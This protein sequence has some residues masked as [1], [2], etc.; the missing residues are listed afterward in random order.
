[1]KG[2]N[3][4]SLSGEETKAQCNQEVTTVY[5]LGAGASVPDDLPLTNE[6]NL[7]VAAYLVEKKAKGRNS[8]LVAY[9]R[10]LYG[11][12]WR[13]LKR[14]A[15]AWE[16]FLEKRTR[17]TDAAARLPNL[18]ETLTLIDLALAENTSF[19]SVSDKAL[20]KGPALEGARL[21]ELRSELTHAIAS[22]IKRAGLYR[23]APHAKAL[24]SRLQP[25]DTVVTTNW[26]VFMDRGIID[27]LN[28]NAKSDQP[29][30][31]NID[32]GAVHARTVNWL[33]KDLPVA[34]A[35]SY[36]LLKL[37]G[38]LNWFYCARCTDLYANVELAW[39]I[40]ST[41]P[42]EDHDFCHCGVPLR[43]IMIAPSYIKDYGNPHLASVWR[44]ALK[45]LRSST[46]WVFIG[47]SL[48]AD[49]FHIRGM[50]LRALRANVDRGKRLDVDVVYC[51]PDEKLVARY[52][53]LLRLATLTF[54]GTGVTKYLGLSAR[55]AAECRD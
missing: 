51:G 34:Q 8:M 36:R 20:F 18:V 23:R 50:L 38:S 7:A 30:A 28:R 40:D 17:Q 24:A 52:K 42:R 45:Q 6:L 54:H 26:D 22:G 49:D 19:G 3:R 2:T 27:V 21:V 16:D 10:Q 47:Y 32:Y 11:I 31:S 48:P 37:H 44:N 43:N 53:D 5:F 35:P 1:M 41:N 14:A 55:G 33:G 25:H 12:R 4:A 13:D 9:Y 39:V 29:L 15:R 46:R